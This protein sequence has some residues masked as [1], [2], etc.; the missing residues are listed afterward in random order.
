MSARLLL[1]QA[2]MSSCRHHRGHG[3]RVAVGR[4]RNRSLLRAAVAAA[5]ESLPSMSLLPPSSSR[6]RPYSPIN[7][8]TSAL[9]ASS[10]WQNSL[11]RSLATSAS[12]CSATTRDDIASASTSSTLTHGEPS[13]AF[14]APPSVTFE[15]LGLDGEVCNALKASGISHPSA[16]QVNVTGSNFTEF[17][18]FRLHSRSHVD[19]LLQL[20]LFRPRRSRTCSLPLTPCSRRRRVPERRSLT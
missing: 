19:L 18:L 16:V 6:L 7:S 13:D 17:L 3:I 9:N 2:L 5:L 12:T 20:T 11:F 10:L 1:L 15:S 4:D 14:L 8:H